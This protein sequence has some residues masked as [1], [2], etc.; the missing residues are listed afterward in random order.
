MRI[1]ENLEV[2]ATHG[3]FAAPPELEEHIHRQFGER[4][5][6]NFSDFATAELIEDIPQQQRAVPRYG[7]IGGDPGRSL[8][9]QDLFR[10][11]DFNGIKIYRKPLPDQVKEEALAASYIPYHR[12]VV[13]HLLR[14]HGDPRNLVVA[15]DLH[16][17]GD[18][19]L[20]PEPMYDVTREAKQ[21]WNMPPVILS[22]RDG[23]TAPEQLMADLQ[24]A[25]QEH[26]GLNADE[27]ECNTRYK[28]GF[29]TQHYGDP[30][31]PQLREAKNPDRAVVQVELKRGLY[32]H[33][34]TQ[35]VLPE[36]M[37][38]YREKLALIFAEVADGYMHHAKP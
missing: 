31:N 2:F 33:E 8:D 15:I 14:V 36:A 11:T 9:A 1:P 18:L 16:D 30:Q 22:N 28:G 19:L 37:R 32:L 20:A 12:A 3:A 26:L 6:R 4:M 29:V 21:G 17:T 13:E 24:A 35:I 25:F 23:Q 38:H 7:R 27:V 5:R 10:P 34:K